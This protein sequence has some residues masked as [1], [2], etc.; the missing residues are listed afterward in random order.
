MSVVPLGGTRGTL[1]LVEAHRRIELHRPLGADPNAV[2]E[3]IRAQLEACGCTCQLIAPR[4]L[5]F[6][7]SPFEGFIGYPVRAATVTL[8]LSSPA[9]A[10]LRLDARMSA[11]MVYGWVVAACLALAFVPDLTFRILGWVGMAVIGFQCRMHPLDGIEDAIRDGVR[12]ATE[13]A[14]LPATTQ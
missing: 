14:R 3:G 8:D 5:A 7:G 4:T 6:D 12:Q 13:A 2:M 11:A 10:A 1:P 9:R